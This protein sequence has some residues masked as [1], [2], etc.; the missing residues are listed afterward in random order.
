VDEAVDPARRGGSE[1]RQR[2][3][4]IALIEA[5]LVGGADDARNV[6]DGVGVGD[7]PVERSAVIEAPADPFDARPLGLIPPGQR[8]DFVPRS[9]CDVDQVR[10][11]EA[12]AASDGELQS[13]DQDRSS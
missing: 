5:R 13:G 8:L 3:I 1:H 12:G 10:A 6:D 11:D 4:D 7:Q 2:A 9:E